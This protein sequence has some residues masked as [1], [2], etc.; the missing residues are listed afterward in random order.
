[1]SVF[2]LALGWSL[3]LLYAIASVLCTLFIVACGYRLA[4]LREERRRRQQRR[5]YLDLTRRG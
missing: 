2:D 3:F 1:M 5:G 4:Q